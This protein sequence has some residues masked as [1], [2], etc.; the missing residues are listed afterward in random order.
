MAVCQKQLI[1]KVFLLEHETTLMPISCGVGQADLLPC[2]LGLP[3]SS[4]ALLG[5]AAAS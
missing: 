5:K 3:G 1:I 4:W 2:S